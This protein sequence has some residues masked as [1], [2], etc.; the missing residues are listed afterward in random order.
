MSDTGLWTTATDTMQAFCP[1][2]QMAMRAV[3]KDVGIQYTWFLLYVARGMHPEPLTVTHMM[4]I[5]PYYT[6]QQQQAALDDLVGCGCLMVQDDAAQAAYA[7]TPK[8]AKAIERVFRIIHRELGKVQAL[9]YAQMRRIAEL[10][11]HA[12]YHA[13][14]APEPVEKAALMCSRWTDMGDY[15][16]AAIAIEQYLTDLSRFRLDC[17]RQVWQ[18]YEISGP[19]WE[20]FSLIGPGESPTARTLRKR[21]Q[22]RGH[23]GEV[24]TQTLQA[25][26]RRGWIAEAAKSG[27]YRVTPAGDALRQEVESA[28][29]ALFWPVLYK[30]GESQLIELVELLD[31]LKA[32]LEPAGRSMSYAARRA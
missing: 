13:L 7:L 4:K 30:L 27:A 15:S 32:V 24:I 12:V 14:H 17:Q 3:V 29:D 10:L 8:G 20:L 28:T 1:H 11:R 22:H 19:M 26:I 21:L 31:S 16:P 23:S 18:T 2:Y 25:L 5:R 6:R 9:P